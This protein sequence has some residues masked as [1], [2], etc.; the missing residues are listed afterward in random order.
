MCT[1]SWLRRSDGYLLLCNRDERH[2]RRPAVGPRLAER[3]GVSLLAPVDG[4]YGGSWIGVNEFGLT[5]CLLN[6]Y[7][8]G[9]TE[10]DRSFTSRGLLL[11]ELLDCARNPQVSKRINRRDLR[12]FQ[13]FTMV[14]L[15]VEEPAMLIEWT[16]AECLVHADS[17]SGMPISSSSMRG[18]DV[19]GERKKQFQEITHAKKLDEQLLYQFH[20]S[21]LPVRGSSSVCMHREDAAT[22]SLSAVNVTSELIEFSYEGGPPCLETPAERVRVH[23][24]QVRT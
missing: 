21:H 24:T 1:V 5:L 15:A 9:L 8:D 14:A 20:R 16:G 23:R 11:L 3:S 4:D 22:V 10:H 13:P 6:R 2:T 17:E 18:L 19:V 12:T 7:G